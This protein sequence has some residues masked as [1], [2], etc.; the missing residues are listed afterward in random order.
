[1]G[2]IAS[3]RMTATERTNAKRIGLASCCYLAVV[4]AR[5]GDTVGYAMVS[6]PETLNEATHNGVK[7]WSRSKFEPSVRFNQKE[8]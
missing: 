4:A 8:T 6:R 1:M 3:R 5:N 2:L 7:L